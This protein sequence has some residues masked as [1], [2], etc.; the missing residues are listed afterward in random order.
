MEGIILEKESLFNFSDEYLRKIRRV[1]R[2]PEK[3]V[4]I[5]FN[6]NQFGEAIITTAVPV[7]TQPDKVSYV[8]KKT[9]PYEKYMQ[10]QLTRK[11]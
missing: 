10:R 8:K 4:V 3:R 7:Q 11:R 9:L 5:G 6:E 1:S 2:E